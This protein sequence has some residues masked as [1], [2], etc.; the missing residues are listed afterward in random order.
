[1]FGPDKCGA[2]S[3]VHFIIQHQNPVTMQWEEKHLNSSISVKTDKIKTHLYTLNIKN[4]ND[5]EIYVDMKLTQKGN[6]LTHMIPSIN[7]S[8]VVDDKDDVIP[9]GN[10]RVRV[11]I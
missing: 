9:E 5:F 2:N 4:S 11:M 8:S 6:L 1:M 3:K 10:V 7:P